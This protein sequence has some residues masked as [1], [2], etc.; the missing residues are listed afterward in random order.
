MARNVSL[1]TWLA[2]ALLAALTSSAYGYGDT[3]SC[4]FGKQGACLDYGDK[5]CS[6][7]AKCVSDDAICFDSYTC[8]YKGFVCKS[9]FEDLFDKCKNIAEEHD[10][11]ADEYNDLVR[12]YRNAV[13]EYE[14]F[15]S[16]VSYASTL[17]EAKNCH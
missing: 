12:K 16:C 17:E 7:S 10:D 14:D 9:K 4:S 6:S 2:A 3:F 8:D 5:I 15:Q 13:S 11:L 1:S